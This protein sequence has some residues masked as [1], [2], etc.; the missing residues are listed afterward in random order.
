MSVAPENEQDW[1]KSSY[2][3]GGGNDCVEV[4]VEVD[5]VGVRDSKHI[6]GPRLQ[7]SPTAWRTFA[8][9]IR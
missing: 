6:A 3:G 9:R 8:H 2:S 7:F 1:R 5:T 4:A